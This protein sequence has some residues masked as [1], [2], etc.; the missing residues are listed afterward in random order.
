MT[1]IARPTLEYAPRDKWRR[2]WPG[3]LLLVA[4]LFGLFVAA[5]WGPPA[6][7]HA[8]K[9]LQLQHERQVLYESCWAFQPLMINAPLYD[10]ATDRGPVLVGDQST[11]LY[12]RSRADPGTRESLP[13]AEWHWNWQSPN[14]ASP[15]SQFE[16]AEARLRG[17]IRCA[18][19]IRTLVT[20]SPPLYWGDEYVVE[21]LVHGRRSTGGTKR[22]VVVRFD[23]PAFVAGA[24]TAFQV[25]TFEPVSLF[26]QTRRQTKRGALAF[27]CDPRQPLKLYPGRPDPA[28][29]SHFAIPYDVGG[30]AGTID[31]WLQDDGTVKL[32]TRDGP[33]LGFVPPEPVVVPPPEPVLA[34]AQ[35]APP[36]FEGPLRPPGLQ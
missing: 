22:L 24:P 34:P 13:A 2:R 6:V 27:G 29:W 3:R 20:R 12:L 16:A 28:D 15:L 5:H 30:V 19:G 26:R 10:E 1:S 18:R 21:L 32:Q 8:R 9:R 25:E 23:A 35:L 14:Q 7:K 33:A 36:T 11:G 4:V 31:G 17:R